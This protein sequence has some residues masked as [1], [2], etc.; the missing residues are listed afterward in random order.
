MGA[1]PAP[2]EPVSYRV[3]RI[4]GA[5][6]EAITT[7]R[8]S[9]VLLLLGGRYRV[10]GRYGVMNAR[11]VRE[12]EVKAGQTQQ[13]TLEHQVASLKLRLLGGSGAALTEVFWDVKDE[14]GATVWT[15]GQAEPSAA[16]Q[17]GRYRV[18]AE[19]REK[20]YDRAIE[21]RAGEARVVE[22]TAN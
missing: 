5:P 16:L 21:L 4:D 3:E 13:L 2:N 8:P 22:L 1:A 14:A 7:S 18:R 15:S 9:P 12:I 19:T 11:V 20:R 6:Q 10:E 17:A